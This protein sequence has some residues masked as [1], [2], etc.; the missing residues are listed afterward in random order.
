MKRHG[1]CATRFPHPVLVWDQGKT[2]H[3]LPSLTCHEVGLQEG[4]LDEIIGHQLSTVD[5]SITSNIGSSPYRRK[6]CLCEARK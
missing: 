1:L 5:N 2:Q 3:H 6:G 4:I